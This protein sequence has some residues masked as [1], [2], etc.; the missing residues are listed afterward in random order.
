MY[1]CT[2]VSMYV[3]TYVYMYVRMCVCMYVCLFVCFF[4][5][6]YVRK[7]LQR[8]RAPPPSLNWTAKRLEEEEICFHDLLHAK[9]AGP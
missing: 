3:C 4:D 5:C 1:V 7:N 9:H 2:Y 6:L 8:S